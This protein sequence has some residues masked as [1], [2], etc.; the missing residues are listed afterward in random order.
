MV[1]SPSERKLLVGL[2]NPGPAYAQQRHN[3]GFMAIDRLA[4]QHGFSPFRRRFHGDLA[5]GRLAARPCLAFK[6]L[7]FMNLSGEPVGELCRFYKLSAEAVFVF[8]DDLDLAPGRLRVKQGGGHAGHN[9]L[10][11]L[12]AHIGPGY[13]RVRLGIGHPGHRDRVHGYVLSDFTAEERLWL[14][15]LLDA[16]AT[17]VPLLVEGDM[18]AFTSRVA[19]A[20]KPPP[21]PADTPP[22]EAARDTERG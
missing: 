4:A 20:L 11:S 3:V 14:E 21:R 16:V 5:E 13:W 10:K 9:G 7:T 18:A 6:P 1:A 12:D 22:G 17:H 19:L 8:H 15:P 2:G